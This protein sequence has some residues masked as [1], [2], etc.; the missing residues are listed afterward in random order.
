MQ[1]LHDDDL[2]EFL[3]KSSD[4]WVV[5]SFPAIAL[6]D[7]QIPI[8][9]GRFYE[10]HIGEVLHPERES[11]SALDKIRSART[12]SLANTNNAQVNPPAI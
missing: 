1:R 2:C 10:R 6:K 4:D 12:S 3:L 11:K 9:D 7:E 8:G 5:L